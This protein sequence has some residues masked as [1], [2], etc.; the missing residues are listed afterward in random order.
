VW[1]LRNAE[2]TAAVIELFVFIIASIPHLQ[3]NTVYNQWPNQMQRRVTNI[4]GE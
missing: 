4:K 2:K 1:H 3:P